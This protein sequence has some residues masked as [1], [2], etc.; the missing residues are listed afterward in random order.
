[1][2]SHVCLTSNIVPHLVV[3]VPGEWQ[4]GV[5][6]MVNSLRQVPTEAMRE[7]EKSKENQRGSVATRRHV[8]KRTAG[9]GSYELTT[10]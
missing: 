10:K 3:F 1:M 5:T 6:S 2:F 9:V 4:P 7:R 8:E